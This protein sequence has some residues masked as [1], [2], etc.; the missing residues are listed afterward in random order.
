MAIPARRVGIIYNPISGKGRGVRTSGALQ[1]MLEQRGLE[2]HCRESAA[3][4]APGQMDQF[5]GVLDALVVAGGDGTLMGILPNLI[6][7]QT[8]VYMCPSGNE[9]LF[10]REYSML[11]NEASVLS[12]LQEGKL[13]RCYLG[14]VGDRPFA[15][16]M[17]VGLDSEVVE[18]ISRYRNKA[19]GHHGYVLPIVSAL[20]GHRLPRISLAVNGRRVIENQS[21][22]LIIANNKQY[23]LRLGLVPEADPQKDELCAR[24]FPYEHIAKLFSWVVKCAFPALFDLSTLPVFRGSS[25][26]LEVDNYSNYPIQADGEYVGV[27]PARVRASGQSIQVLHL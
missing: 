14:R 25:F 8:P 1:R 18:R 6:A 24:L 20:P 7:S 26:E 3:H 5:F 15:T 10:A 9:S 4:Y 23:A 13:S 19:I 16:M 12:A 21:G 2:V 17:S 22:L 11:P 27:A